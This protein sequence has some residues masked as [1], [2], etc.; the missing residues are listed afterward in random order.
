MVTETRKKLFKDS[1]EESKNI[2]ESNADAELDNTQ[3]TSGSEKTKAN[4]KALL[5]NSRKTLFGN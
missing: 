5:G 2:K 4:D 1:D 3:N